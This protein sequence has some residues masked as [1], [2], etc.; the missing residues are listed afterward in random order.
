VFVVSLRWD[1]EFIGNE[2]NE[3]MENETPFVM[4][5]ASFASNAS[6]TF[7]FL[8]RIIGKYNSSHLL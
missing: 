1:P 7:V 4:I 5:T 2:E 8:F 3:S 6:D